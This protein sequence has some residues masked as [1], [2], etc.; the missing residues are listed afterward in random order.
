MKITFDQSARDFVL[1]AFNKKI[2]KGYLVESDNPEQKV[3][4]KDGHDIQQ[5][6]F[7]GIR[8]GSEIYIRSDIVSLIELCDDMKKKSEQNGMAR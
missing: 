1:E 5:N 4:A 7:A 6:R 2:E 8:K 3:L